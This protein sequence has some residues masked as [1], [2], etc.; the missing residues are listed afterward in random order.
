MMADAV[1]LTDQVEAYHSWKKELVRNITR[2]R[3][4]LQFNELLEGD[5][6]RHLQRSIR[7]LVEDELTIAFVGEYS[8]GKTELIN[9]LFFAGHGQRLLPSEAGRT[10]MCPTELF[11][12]R[13]ARTSYLMLLPIE[14][15]NGAMSL[16]Q[17]RHES[18]AWET[19][20]LDPADT[21]TMA[22]TLARVAETRT[23][24]RAEAAD[25]GFND[26]MLDAS[27]DDPAQV[28]IP[29]W[30]HALISLQHPILER[31]L[32]ILDTPG[33]NALGSEPELTVSML[34]SAQAVVFLLAADAGVTASD[35]TIWNEHIDT[36]DADHRAGRF[37]ILNKIDVLWDDPSG[38]DH[39]GNA[40]ERVRETTARQLGLGMED[41]L[42][43]SAKQGLLARIRD[44]DGLRR[45][46]GVAQL[47]ELV[48]ER[49]LGRREQLISS[50]LV[51]DLRS[52]I[53]DNQAELENQKASLD[54]EFELLQ[55]QGTDRQEI[56]ELAEKTR[57]DYDFFNRRLITLKSSRRLMASQGD[58]LRRILNPERFEQHAERTR[59]RLEGSWTTP[60]LA[61]AMNALFEVLE[62][63]FNNLMAE[64][65]RAEKMVGSIYRRHTSGDDDRTLEPVPLRLG[66][67][68]I[69]LRDLRSRADRFRR[70]PRS[71]L[72]QQSR[73][74]QQFLTTIV[75]EAR[76][77][78][79]RTMQDID[80]WPGEALMPLLQHTQQQKQRLETQFQRLRH[81]VDDEKELKAEADKLRQQRE[82]LD[83]QLRV[84]RK[85]EEGIAPPPGAQLP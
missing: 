8:R 79:H 31:G 27:P 68:L 32:R 18:G 36:R 26:A 24:P 53:R 23:V 78:I 69:A 14:T 42:P 30:R 66:R 59:Q 34:P 60:G 81:I 16:Q 49:I 35:M 75:S 33:L 57:H 62:N 76:Q 11:Y 21:E 19:V 2:Y 29:A 71:L 51:S 5:I 46:S 44:D 50:E 39:T 58:M 74:I 70:D 82:T 84:A 52:M 43:V 77:I 63:D 12:D 61:S 54:A 15:R 65:R 37:A 20:T 3:R 17:L 72:M 28:L 41:V 7:L 48:S 73:L 64:G 45:K 25:L 47:E 9:A 56:A 85:L 80:R 40:I 10:T 1:T 55:A 38:S 67:H 13:H 6:E 83:Q 4:W 22:A